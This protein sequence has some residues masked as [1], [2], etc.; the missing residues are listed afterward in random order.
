[1][2]IGDTT[3]V[4]G[5]YQ[6]RRALEVMVDWMQD[7]FEPWLRR[8]FRIGLAIAEGLNISERELASLV[9]PCSDF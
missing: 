3:S 7:R 9:R 4:L 6:L 5:T 1:M 8:Q 2:A